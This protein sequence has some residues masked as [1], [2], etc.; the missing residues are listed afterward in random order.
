[1]A[2]TILTLLLAF[3]LLWTGGCTFVTTRPK[4]TVRT[5]FHLSPEA[6][7]SNGNE[8]EQAMDRVTDTR[9]TGGNG[10]T[11]LTNGEQVFPAMLAAI[12]SAQTRVSLET[13]IIRM[14][15][16]GE[17]FSQAL[18]RAAK[19][20]VKVR[21]LCDAVGSRT[22]NAKTFQALTQA[23]GEVRFFN[24]L[25]SWTAIRLNNR[26]HRKI[27]VVDG[28][29]AFMGGLN[30]AK[31]YDGDGATGWRDTAVQIVGPA[32]LEAE[33]IFAASWVQGG[34]NFLGKDL[35]VVGLSPIKR[36]IDIPFIK[37]LRRETGFIPKAPHMNHT[38]G[39]AHVRAVASS[40]ERLAST[41]LDLYLLAINSAQERVYITCG[42]FIP[43]RILSRALIRAARRGVDVRLITQGKTDEPTVR[44]ISIGFYGRL[45]REGIRIY[46]WQ[47]TIVHAKIMV[48]D[49]HWSTIGSANLDG[50]ALFLNYEANFAIT[51]ARLAGAMIEQFSRDLENCREIDLTAWQHRSFKQKAGE[52]ILTPLEDQF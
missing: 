49:N 5:L 26:D 25:T 38:N 4:N 37:L 42:Y 50:R 45:L 41:L 18:L 35:P 40:P 33:R 47:E 8:F 46:E 16:V 6:P 9:L 27:L 20:G 52:M 7:S 34:D 24:P 12:D 48:V 31:E 10:A 2:K 11:L 1:M 51:S 14:D 21:F 17:R 32:A 30:L 15:S 36:A 3:P 19:R 44:R 22:V 23:E 13:Y 39:Q 43:P 28:T 29:T